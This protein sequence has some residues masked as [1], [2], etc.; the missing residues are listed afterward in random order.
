MKWHAANS[1]IA[2]EIT[3]IMPSDNYIFVPNL[4]ISYTDKQAFILLCIIWISINSA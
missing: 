1:G 4:L 3:N 2:Y